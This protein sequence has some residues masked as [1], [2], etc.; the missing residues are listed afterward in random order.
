MS[1]TRPKSKPLDR[2]AKY[3]NFPLVLACLCVSLLLNGCTLD[4]V[5]AESKP[6]GAAWINTQGKPI[7]DFEC[8][9][10][11]PFKG[12]LAPVQVGAKWGYMDKHGRLAIPAEF[13]YATYFEN[14]R[15]AVA[16]G[17]KGHNL[18]D[19]SWGVIDEKGRFIISPQYRDL[20]LFHD[21]LARAAVSTTNGIKYG[22]IDKNL[23]FVIKPQFNYA[24]DF[25]EGLAAVNIGQGI[26]STGYCE[27]SGKVVIPAK[28]SVAENFKNGVARVIEKHEYEYIDKYG[29]AVSRELGLQSFPNESELTPI[30]VGDLYGYE[31]RVGKIVIRP[32]YRRAFPFSDGYAAAVPKEGSFGYGVIDKTGS[33]ISPTKFGTIRQFSEGLAAAQL[34]PNGKWG[35]I[36]PSGET[37]IQFKFDQVGNFSNGLAP[38]GFED[39]WAEPF[40]ARTQMYLMGYVDKTGE[41]A[42]KPKY[43]QAEDFK[44][45][46]AAVS[47]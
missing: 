27:L 2:L 39:G 10:T 1:D 42:L 11:I 13:A 16:V 36:T 8:A 34:D 31:D 29:K 12:D 5:G 14:G 33:F 7:H 30:K 38:A 28:F 4:E 3:A 47:F 26:R 22:Y 19:F 15:A 23:S 44:D 6:H 35:F 24:R 21:G 37:A 32:A 43:H 41:F 18:R 25:S 40:D 46:I 17:D 45:G 20:G 9:A